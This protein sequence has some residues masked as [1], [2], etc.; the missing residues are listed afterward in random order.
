MVYIGMEN[1]QT[2]LRFDGR[3]KDFPGDNRQWTIMTHFLDASGRDRF[4]S[5]FFIGGLIELGIINGGN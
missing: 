1:K 5:S 4:R 3:W 2:I